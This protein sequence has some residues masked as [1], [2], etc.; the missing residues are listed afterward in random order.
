M[1]LY[2]SNRAE[3]LMDALA[4]VLG[5][6]LADPLA[7]ELVVVQS[8]GM[9]RWLSMQLSQRLGIAANLSFPF[10]RH[11]I[12]RAFDVV[13]GEAEELAKPYAREALVWS[14]AAIL[15]EHDREPAFAEAREYTAGDDGGVLRLQLARRLAQALDDYAV[16]RPEL[17]LGWERG[18]EPGDL[19][20]ELFRAVVARHGAFHQAARAHRL[21]TALRTR[22]HAGPID[23]L[24][25]RVCLF[26]I[27]TLPPLYVELLSALSRHVETHLFVL[28]PSSEY[29][30]EARERRD[31]TYEGHPL[32]AALGKLGRDLQTILSGIEHSEPFE[33]LFEDP[34]QGSVLHSLQ[35]DMLQLCDR[36]RSEGAPRL[37]IAPQDRSISVHACHSPMREI[38]VLHDQL[39]ALLEDPALEPHDIVVMAPDIEAYAPVIEAVF[40][41]A[42]IGESSTRPF[43]PHSVAHRGLKPESAAFDALQAALDILSQRVTASAVLDLLSREPVYVH[44]GLVPEDLETLRTWVEEAGIH[45]GV[46]E[47]DRGEAGQPPLVEGTFRFGLE[48]ML[49]GYAL[50]GRGRTL[51]SGRLPLDAVQGTRAVLAG[52]FAELCEGLFAERAAVRARH[53]VAEWGAL[54]ER[55]LVLLVGDRDEHSAERVTIRSAFADL[56][57]Q[58]EVAQFRE[59]IALRA[60]MPALEGALEARTAARGYLSR[61]VTF[62]QL[63]PM[64]S[65][66]FKVVCLVG[67]GDD[68]FPSRRPVQGFDRMQRAPKPGDRIARDDDRH[69]FLEAL[70]GAREHFIVTYVGRSAHD[71]REQPAAVVVTDL[72]DA[73]AR[74]FTVPRQPAGEPPEPTASLDPR[75]A[76]EQRLVVRHRLHPFSPH[77]F[78]RSEDSRLFSYATSYSSG[79][80]AIGMAER[81]TGLKAD[82]LFVP[83]PLV[84]APLEELRLDELIR[85]LTRPARTLLSNL[86]VSVEH[87]VVVISEREPTQLG[88]LEAWDLRD[89]LSRMLLEDPRLGDAALIERVRARGIIPIGANGTLDVSEL[90]APMR[91]LVA[92]AVSYRQGEPLPPEPV[93][94]MVDGVRIVG[95]LRALWPLAQ[96][97]VSVS[98]EGKAFELKHFVRHV[99]LGALRAQGKRHLP[100]RSAVVARRESGDAPYV[101]ELAELEEPYRILQDYVAFVREARRGN[102]AFEYAA[103]SA[104]A[105]RLAETQDVSA[106]LERAR[107]ALKSAAK[108][109]LREEKLLWGDPGSVLEG[110]RRAAFE[111]QAM[112]ILG[113]MI[114]SRREIDLA[115]RGAAS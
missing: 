106:A 64:R 54:I 48:R 46:D 19:Q 78:G 61:G 60:L 112:R 102:F 1:R 92:A 31:G 4:S 87:D 3:R 13:L 42:A 70:L 45:W 114:R 84:R 85:W 37:A 100:A 35:S 43:I 111:E 69:V 99:V 29:L 101:V 16:Y 82:P 40:A 65:V 80:R 24:P 63:V 25:Q 73:I 56:I 38:E 47:R 30:E 39:C 105:E 95:A 8:R 88:G 107:V 104:Y 109:Y 44:R 58:A 72:L 53:T 93:D 96:L 74:G 33:S 81:E 91:A 86:G 67:M 115:G 110:E 12:E 17:L 89:E 94:L 52:S 59:P 75:R 113:P 7:A 22:A 15:A 77:Y 51:F 34:G 68:R 10:P 98:K 71:D 5:E 103:A 20:A 57:A 9:E 83:R 55:L 79:A 6:P 18:E 62:C 32:I 28:T 21:L 90:I 11:F 41:H 50:E 2:R 97:D 66:P 49:L 27:A 76:I 14:V 26:G 23:G 36:G 108:L